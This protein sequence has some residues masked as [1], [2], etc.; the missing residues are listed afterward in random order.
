MEAREAKNAGREASARTT[1]AS[2]L[3]GIALHLVMALLLVAGD[4]VTKVLI[5]RSVSMGQSLPLIAPWLRI[6]HVQNTGAA[7]SILAE[8][9][10]FLIGIALAVGLL[11]WW[12]RHYILRQAAPFRWGLTLSMSGALGNLI[13]R[14][15]LGR[16]IDFIALRG[17]PIFNLADIFIVVGVGLMVGAILWANSSEDTVQSDCG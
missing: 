14:I 5:C 10:P 1:D 7:F 15:R 16:V 17:W 12:N 6:T 4:Q 3:G 2:G 8:Q 11:A 13:D 9:T